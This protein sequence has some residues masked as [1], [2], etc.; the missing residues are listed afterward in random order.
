MNI[1]NW[2]AVTVTFAV[3]IVS[4]SGCKTKV[5]CPAYSKSHPYKKA[6]RS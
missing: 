3:L 6:S 4:T 1:K 5:D 2:I